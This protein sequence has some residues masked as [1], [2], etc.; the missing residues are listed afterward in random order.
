MTTNNK[1]VRPEAIDR[2]TIPSDVSNDNKQPQQQHQQHNSCIDKCCYNPR[3]VG[4]DF[5]AKAKWRFITDTELD[6]TPAEVYAIFLDD[7]AWN[8]WHPEISGIHWITSDPKGVGS[9]RI[10]LFGKMEV[11]EEFLAMDTNARLTFRFNHVS[12]PTCMNFN[13]MVEDFI[14]VEL[15]DNRCRLVRTVNADPGMLYCYSWFL[16]NNLIYENSMTIYKNT[17]VVF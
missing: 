8:I 17:H 1:A 13:A 11:T 2:S 15:P 10:I 7:D 14:L 3:S 16:Y 9:K 6:A 4:L 5:I 12:K